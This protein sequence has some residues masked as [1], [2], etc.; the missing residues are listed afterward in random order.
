[1]SVRHADGMTIRSESEIRDALSR[2]C[3]TVW[4][5]SAAKRPL[6]H[7]PVRDDDVDVILYDAFDELKRGNYPLD[8]YCP[9]AVRLAVRTRPNEVSR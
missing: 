2:M 1:M 3:D 7:I 9:G 4:N 6:W 8:G 5:R